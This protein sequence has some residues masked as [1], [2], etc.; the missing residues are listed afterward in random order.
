M[1]LTESGRNNKIGI[2]KKRMISFVSITVYKGLILTIDFIQQ[3]E[4]LNP[5]SFHITYYSKIGAIY[6]TI[7]D[8]N[9]ERNDPED[10]P[11]IPAY[12]A[13][14]DNGNVSYKSHWKYGTRYN[15]I[16]AD[17]TTYYENGNVRSE[18]YKIDYDTQK[19]TY[20]VCYNEDG[21]INN[22][23]YFVDGLYYTEEQF[24]DK[25]VKV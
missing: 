21:S 16:G 15:A 9:G 22:K 17:T 11:H 23:K 7:F 20:T 2:W 18:I 12:C 4:F 24:Y 6:N 1:D 14:Y 3:D 19:Y 25:I 13:Y 8:V 10:F 5:N